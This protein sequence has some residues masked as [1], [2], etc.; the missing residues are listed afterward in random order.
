MSHVACG[1]SG[2]F[3]YLIREGV[4][5]TIDL[6]PDFFA[7]LHVPYVSGCVGSPYLHLCGGAGDRTLVF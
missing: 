1:D 6:L 4:G 3:S 2:A 7:L 5:C